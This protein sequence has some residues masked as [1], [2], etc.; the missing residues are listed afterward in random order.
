MPIARTTSGKQFDVADGE[1]LLDAALR[2][3]VT[4]AY[5]CRTGRCSTCKGKANSGSTVALHD[6]LG[7]TPE[8]RQAGWIL[9][10]VRSATSDVDLEVEDLGNVQLP[11]PRTLPCRIQALEKV[12]PDVLKVLLRMPPNSRFDFQAGQY[13][14]VIGPGGMRRSYSIANAPGTQDP[15]ELH[16]RHFDGGQ[17]SR[18]WFEQAKANDLLRLHGPLGTFFLRETQGLHLVFLATGTG[19][20][21]V[22]SMLERLARHHEKPASITVY[23]GNRV[24]ADHY[25]DAALPQAGQ[26]YVPVLSRAGDEWAGARG[27]VQDVMLQTP[28]D[29]AR[30]RVYACGYDA[31]I[32][33]ARDQLVAAGL[34]ERHFHSDA[35]VCSAA[36]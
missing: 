33:S 35:F 8:E 29:W 12:T 14:E 18:Y 26:R 34:A 7:L 32:H 6:E 21:P 30:T 17:M 16:I 36:T 10:C 1:S 28:H 5:S 25:W 27:H 4:L 9:T 15:L 2:A 11:D 19:I 20:A 22:K 23:W 13:I 3:H 24:A 31:M